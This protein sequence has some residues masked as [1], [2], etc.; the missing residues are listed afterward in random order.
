MRVLLAVVAALA[1]APAASAFTPLHGH[2][3]GTSDRGSTVTFWQQNDLAV[4]T[5]IEDAPGGAGEAIAVTG[6]FLTRQR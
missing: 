6:E 1:L 3:S 2:Y 4:A 5:F